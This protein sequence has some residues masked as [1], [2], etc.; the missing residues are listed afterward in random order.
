[1]NE[2]EHAFRNR[3]KDGAMG[4][5][6]AGISKSPLHARLAFAS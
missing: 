3:L 4:A 6:P 1:M 5:L 2:R